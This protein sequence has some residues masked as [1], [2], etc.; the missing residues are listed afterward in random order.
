V[1]D[2]FGNLVE[3]Q[4]TTSLGE[5][6]FDA[7]PL[8]EYRVVVVIP[9][10]GTR[11]TL[12]HGT[13]L[14]VTLDVPGHFPDN[15]F[16]FVPLPPQPVL[17]AWFPIPLSIPAGL[18]PSRDI[19]LAAGVVLL[20]VGSVLLR[21]RRRAAQGP[22]LEEVAL[23]GREQRTVGIGSRESRPPLFTARPVA[24]ELAPLVAPVAPAAPV[25]RPVTDLRPLAWLVA[26]GL[27]VL[28]VARRRCRRLRGI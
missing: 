7:L 21:R 6:R 25:A 2:V 23:E 4:V 28:S 3:D 18:D 9:P 19:P 16:A 24:E 11:S 22:V 1:Y 5:Y 15:D 12:A 26:G 17:A 8:G 14:A 20:V 13:T 27:V 10:A